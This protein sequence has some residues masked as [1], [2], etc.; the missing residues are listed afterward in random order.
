[1][2]SRPRSTRSIWKGTT[3]RRRMPDGDQDAGAAGAGWFSLHNHYQGGTLTAHSTVFWCPAAKV[4]ETPHFWFI[5]RFNQQEVFQLD[6][7]TGTSPARG[8]LVGDLPVNEYAQISQRG[9][10]R[11]P[12]RAHHCGARPFGACAPRPEHAAHPYT[13]DLGLGQA[14]PVYGEKPPGP[15]EFHIAAFGQLPCLLGPD[16][17]DDPVNDRSGTRGSSR[18]KIAFSRQASGSP[19]VPC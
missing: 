12:F 16:I 15:G 9:A 1:M 17:V 10:Q 19:A 6:L 5:A 7:R 3:D 2:F 18:R 4:S 11:L 8:A 13:S 14:L